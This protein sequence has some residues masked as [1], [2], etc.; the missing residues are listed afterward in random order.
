MARPTSSRISPG[1]PTVCTI[2]CRPAARIS[3]AD[4][5]QAGPCEPGLARAGAVVRLGGVLRHLA[6]PEQAQQAAHL[7]KRSAPGLLHLGHGGHPPSRAAADRP[8][9]PLRLGP[10]PAWLGGDD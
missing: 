3:S 5:R 10:N 7:L 9:R 2:T 8:L 4:V 1:S 6:G